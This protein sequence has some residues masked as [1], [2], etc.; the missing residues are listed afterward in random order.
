MQ[1]IRRKEHTFVQGNKKMISSNNWDHFRSECDWLCLIYHWESCQELSLAFKRN[2]FIDCSICVI[3]MKLQMGTW[4]L[5]L[6]WAKKKK[7]RD[8]TLP[9]HGSGLEEIFSMRMVKNW[10]KLSREVVSSSSLC[11]QLI[12]QGFGSWGDAEMVTLR[13]VQQLTYWDS[14]WRAA[15]CGKPHGISTGEEQHP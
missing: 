3:G 14:P 4:A 5:I 10:N 8:T 2:T 7:E 1:M 13:R 11:I 12:R 15:A 9:I 6:C